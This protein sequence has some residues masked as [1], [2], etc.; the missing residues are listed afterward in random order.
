M[1]K[2]NHSIYLITLLLLLLASCE[3]GIDSVTVESTIYLPQSGLSVQTPLLG[4]SAFNLG[5]CKSGI[6]QNSDAITVSLGID[7]LS[8]DKF[9]AANPGYEILPSEFYTLPDET[10]SIGK[11]SEREFYHINIKGIS[12]LFTGKKYILPIKI[13]GVEPDARIDTTRRVALLQFSRFRN[14]YESKYKMFGQ[15]V[16]AGTTNTDLLKLDEVISGI[17]VNANA[18]QVEGA[19]SGLNL[20]LTVLNGQ[21]QI[22]GAAGS[23][24]YNV[25]NTTGKT[26]T[27]AGE[28]DEIYQCNKGVFTLYYTYTI[29]GKQMD[30][31][32]ELKFWL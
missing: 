16:L 22:K 26:S 20:V 17:S 31:S 30:V 4:N 9:I 11:G 1:M 12:E 21:V 15:A 29:T 3:N 10:V 27:Y 24:V 5:V 2:N 23:E 8:G 19:I 18:I 32:A 7:Q 25:Q 13:K 28:F 14:I 6:N